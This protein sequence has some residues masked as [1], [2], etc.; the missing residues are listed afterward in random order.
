MR[1]TTARAGSTP[2]VDLQAIVDANKIASPEHFV[3]YF[4]SFLYD[5]TLDGDRRTQLINYFTAGDSGRSA[6]HI[7]L[8]GGQSYPI[9]RARGTLYLMMAAPEYHLN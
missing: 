8:S 3:D 7:T 1:G 6:Y 5:G 9:N 4:A 2:P